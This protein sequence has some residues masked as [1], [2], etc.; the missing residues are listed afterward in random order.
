[1]K[2]IDK[3]YIDE[4]EK[5]IIESFLRGEWKELTAQEL[6]ENNILLKQAKATEKTLK[7]KIT[8]NLLKSDIPLI[9]AK[10]KDEGI[11]YQTF[12]RQIIHKIAIDKIKI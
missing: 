9:Q 1:M 4:D 6:K 12:I 8:I 2:L 5:N 7:Q 3:K 10:A 11:P